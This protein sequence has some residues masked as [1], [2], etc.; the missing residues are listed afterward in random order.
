MPVQRQDRSTV[1][2]TKMIAMRTSTLPLGPHLRSGLTQ[3]HNVS[4][5]SNVCDPCCLGVW[6]NPVCWGPWA[7]VGQNLKRN[8]VSKD[9]TVIINSH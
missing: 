8:C 9:F 3:S 4:R 7:C 5:L 1:C 6:L 2:V